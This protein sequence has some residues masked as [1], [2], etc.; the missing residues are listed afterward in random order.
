MCTQAAGATPDWKGNMGITHSREAVYRFLYE[1]RV[2]HPNTF[3]SPKDLEPFAETGQ[4]AA[5][6][7]CGVEL[8]HL[9]RYRK[10]YKLTA[11]GMMYAESQ[12]WTEE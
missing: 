4:L 7:S 5:V 10:H 12:G 2:E 8:G 9:E 1:M 6:L 11:Q 3:Y